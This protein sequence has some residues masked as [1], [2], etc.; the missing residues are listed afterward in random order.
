LKVKGMSEMAGKLESAWDA[1]TVRV[2]EDRVTLSDGSTARFVMWG[3]S[4]GHWTD[5]DGVALKGR[6]R[7]EA[8]ATARFESEVA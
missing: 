2:D 6:A 5:K 7:R 3:T 8:E 1:E 4:P